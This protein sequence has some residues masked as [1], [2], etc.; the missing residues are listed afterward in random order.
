M[1]HHDDEDGHYGGMVGAFIAFAWFAWHLSIYWQPQKDA[2]WKCCFCCD[3]NTRIKNNVTRLCCGWLS[4]YTWC[5]ATIIAM[6]VLEI[7]AGCL[8][9]CD[10]IDD[11]SLEHAKERQK[12]YL[13]ASHDY[14]APSSQSIERGNK[15]V[16][17]LESGIATTENP[18][19]NGR[20]AQGPDGGETKRD[21]EARVRIKSGQTIRMETVGGAQI[22]LVTGLR[23]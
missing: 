7:C 17:K 18:M 22:E 8:K 9:S 5:G 4:C 21:D 19:I 3:K 10:F 11:W 12:T 15:T 20:P 13:I 2:T 14:V 6:T 16:A 23:M 1:T